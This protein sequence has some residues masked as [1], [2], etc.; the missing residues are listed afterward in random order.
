[1]YYMAYQFFSYSVKT[2]KR[3]SQWTTL[4]DQRPNLSH[5]VQLPFLYLIHLWSFLREKSFDKLL[6]AISSAGSQKLS[7]LVNSISNH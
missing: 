4:A 5:A 7:F 3:V 1:M 6:S 2:D